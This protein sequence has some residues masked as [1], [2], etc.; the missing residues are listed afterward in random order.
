MLLSSLSMLLYKYSTFILLFPLYT[1]GCKLHTHSPHSHP[2]SVTKMGLLRT[3]YSLAADAAFGINITSTA[4]SNLDIIAKLLP[5]ALLMQGG[6]RKQETLLWTETG[7]TIMLNFPAE[8]K[9]LPTLFV[10]MGAPCPKQ[11]LFSSTRD[12]S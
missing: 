3:P 1:R 4:K 9:S 12:V 11:S 5:P 2:L 7:C 8:R 6:S 10:I